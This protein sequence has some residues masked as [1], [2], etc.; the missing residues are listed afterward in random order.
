MKKIEF[1]DEELVIVFILLFSI[2][3]EEGRQNEQVPFIDFQWS[4]AVLFCICLGL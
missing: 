1:Q 3:E 2:W 4:L